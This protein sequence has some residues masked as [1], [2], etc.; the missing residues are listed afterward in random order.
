MQETDKTPQEL[1]EE[2]S[3]KLGHQTGY[4]VARNEPLVAAEI[5]NLRS[6]EPFIKGLK[7]GKEAYERELA[8]SHQQKMPEWLQQ[9]RTKVEFNDKSLDR[10]KDRDLELGR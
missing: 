4:M 2:Q 10:N 6:D 3:F 5:N 1:W 9:N 7:S 8:L